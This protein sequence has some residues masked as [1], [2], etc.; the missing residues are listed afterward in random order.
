MNG[1]VSVIIPTFNRADKLLPVVTAVLSQTGVDVQPIVVDDCSTDGTYEYLSDRFGRQIQL[2]RTPSPSG[3]PSLP[4]NIGMAKASG[5]FIAFCDSDD[6]WRPEHLQQ[7]TNAL[8]ESTKRIYSANADIVWETPS[9]Q[10]ETRLFFSTRP[11]SIT[12]LDLIRRNFVITSGLVVDSSLIKRSPGFPVQQR[13]PIYE[14]W[15]LW[16][17]LSKESEIL[18]DPRPTVDYRI[19]SP[20]SF[21]RHY[22]PAGMTTCRTFRWVN[23]AVVET[24]G[25]LSRKERSAMFQTVIRQHAI[26]AQNGFRY[27]MG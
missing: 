27:L 4:R 24:G 20:D 1:H 12:T 22:G 3:T 15:A 25:S 21:A 17:I 8:R 10:L 6:V 23:D 11:A 13:A 2:C 26:L 18:C 9:G 5:E 14:D 7:A 16:L 19:G